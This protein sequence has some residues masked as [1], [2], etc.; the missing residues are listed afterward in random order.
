M[1]KISSPFLYDSTGQTC[2]NIETVLID[3]GA[4][5]TVKYILDKDR[6]NSECRAYPI[7]FDPSITSLD[8]VRKGARK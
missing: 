4:T 3:N 2:E 8:Y 1:F 6:M 5:V 7:T